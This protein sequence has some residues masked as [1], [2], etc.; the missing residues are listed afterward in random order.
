MGRS[1]KKGPFVNQKLL[2]KIDKMNETP[3]KKP[4]KT[5]ARASM[6]T[7]DFVGHTFMVH[8]G[9]DFISVYVTENMVGH[10]LGE[11][12]PTR[13]FK[14]HGAHTAKVSK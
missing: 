2:I 14:G 6:I 10:K 4:I 1:L 12:S 5:W 3:L 11:F 7:P 9:K 13:T 8:N